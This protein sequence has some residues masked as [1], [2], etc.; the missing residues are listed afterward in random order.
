[1]V[2]TLNVLLEKQSGVTSATG[3]Y[4]VIFKTQTCIASK[5]I[6]RICV[7]TNFMYGKHL[8]FSPWK[9]I[10]DIKSIVAYFT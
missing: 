1:M 6:I 4:N 3:H 2:L 5:F 9:N 10:L 8:W 7:E